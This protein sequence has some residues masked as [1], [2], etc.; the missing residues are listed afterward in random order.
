MFMMIYS[1]ELIKKAYDDFARRYAE[2]NFNVIL[3]Y[4]L[5]EFLSFLPKSA[6]IL[7]LG[8]GPGRDVN[9]FLEEGYNAIGIDFSEKMIKEAKAR[10]KG[11][12]IVMNFNNMDFKD[13]EFNGLWC[14]A[15]VIHIPK[16]LINK[17]L[18]EFNRV[19]KPGGILF[20]SV[21]KGEGE[22]EFERRSFY[23]GKLPVSFYNKDEISKILEKNGFKVLRIFEDSDDENEWIDLICRKRF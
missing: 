16:R 11:K 4:Q 1:E 10:V 9:Y 17:T 20:V 7:D 2:I 15:S 19:L 14:N 21:M 5:N 6:K 8:C 18:K 3:Q 23:N 12:F 22:M 13:E